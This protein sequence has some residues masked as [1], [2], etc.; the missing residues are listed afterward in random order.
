MWYFGW[1]GLRLG[2]LGR[3]ADAVD[4]TDA[5]GRAGLGAAPGLAWPGGRRL[6]AFE[7]ADAEGADVAAGG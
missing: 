3:A 5:A 7:A 4:G 1:D 6:E 2:R